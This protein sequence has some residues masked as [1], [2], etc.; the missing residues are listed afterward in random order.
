MQRKYFGTDAIR[1]RS[2]NGAIT[3]EIM[4]KL[5]RANSL[6]CDLLGKNQL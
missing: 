3:P 1:G 4:I 5:A 6:A 2:N